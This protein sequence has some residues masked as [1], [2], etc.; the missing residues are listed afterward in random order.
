M[1]PPRHTTHIS[2]S[3]DSGQALSAAVL[4]V[5]GSHF[6][7]LYLLATCAAVQRR[8]YG[9]ALVRQLEQ[10]LA[11]SG[12]SRDFVAGGG[13]GG[14]GGIVCDW[15]GGRFNGRLRFARESWRA[16]FLPPR[17]GPS[18]FPFP[19]NQCNP[20]LLIYIH[21]LFDSQNGPTA[22]PLQACGGFWCRWTMTTWSIR[23]CGTTRWGLGPCLTQSSGSWRGAGGRSGRRR[24][25][26]PCSCTGP[27]LAELAR[28]RGRGSTA[29]GDA[30]Q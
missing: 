28:R 18:P 13:S 5:Y 16:S 22:I 15:G 3:Q 24:G 25:A 29:S 1:T 10:E 30:M 23:G 7:E 8:G 17:P 19:R 12:E 21:H 9:R 11:A 26:A 27:C 4:D 14:H 2:P 6:A 20:L